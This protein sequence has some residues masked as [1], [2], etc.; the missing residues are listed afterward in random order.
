MRN[1]TDLIA[2]PWETFPSVQP[3]IKK[4]MR[5]WKEKIF[6]DRLT[7]DLPKANGMNK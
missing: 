5:K 1:V 4:N 6:T 3:G 2:T 7:T